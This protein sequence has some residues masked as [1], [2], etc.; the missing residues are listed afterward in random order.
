MIITAF[1]RKQPSWLESLIKPYRSHARVAILLGVVTLACSALLMFV[2]GYL[3]SRTA[4]A[5][6]TLFAVMIPIALVQVFGIGRPFARYF[7]RLISHD[8]VFRVTSKLRRALYNAIDADASLPNTAESTGAYLDT[9]AVDISNLQNLYLRVAFPTIIA[10]I[11]LISASIFFGA[12]SIGIG[13]AVFISGAISAILLPI[14]S[15]TLSKPVIHKT[16]SLR[17]SESKSLT[18]DIM[19]A[20]DWS[21]SGR[22]QEAL[23]KHSLANAT[24]TQY[25]YLTRRRTRLFELF[26]ALIL[27]CSMSVVVI[28]AGNSLQNSTDS[29]NLIAACALGFFPLIEVFLLLPSALTTAVTHEYALESLNKTLNQ[30]GITTSSREEQNSHNEDDSIDNCDIQLKRVSYRYPKAINPTLKNIDLKIPAGKSL[31]LLGRSGSGKTTCAS[32]L[33][34]SLIPDAGTITLG[35]TALTDTCILKSLVGYIPQS[36]YIFD[37]TLRD[38]LL[39]AK[40]DASDNELIAALEQVGLGEK[41]NSLE[42]GLDTSI[43]ETGV[44]FSGG[45]AHRLALARILLADYPIVLLDEP[46]VAVDPATEHRLLET[47]FA[48]TT[49]KTLIVITHHLADIQR[50]DHIAFIED[51]VVTK[52]G[53]PR[54]LLR[55]DPWFKNLVELDYS[56]TNQQLPEQ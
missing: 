23:E 44:G 8:W 41:L 16:R 14:A 52:E 21:I 56:F 10:L 22:H 37:R 26:S 43:G 25:D 51:G 45:E 12:L 15:Y 40:P 29:C 13:L 30:N 31:A 47:L 4:Q 54:N 9:L 50:F 48:A 11:L 53:S 39:I 18:D 34:G 24:K 7:E 32:I 35:G 38:N 19:G 6:A 1:R 42:A 36:P 27:V 55:D 2:S 46:F 20:L 3:I 33:R 5:G 49:H 17:V 28:L